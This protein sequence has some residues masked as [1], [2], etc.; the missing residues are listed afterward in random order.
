MSEDHRSRL[1]SDVYSG[2]KQ[3]SIKRYE[4]RGAGSGRSNRHV[5]Y[6]NITNYDHYNQGGWDQIGQHI[7]IKN[8]NSDDE[9]RRLYDFM[10][11]YKPAPKAAAPVKAAA[12][13]KAATP[14]FD[15]RIE[16]IN[17]SY[18]AETKRLTDLMSKQQKDYE[19]RSTNQLNAFNQRSAEQQAAFDKYSASQDK[20]ISNL[21]NSV[22]NAASQFDPTENM[23]SSNNINPALTIQEKGKTLSKGTSRYNRNSA[24]NIQNVNV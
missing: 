22:A 21:S 3:R 6:Q 14:A 4:S 1:M 24:L 2:Y 16:D 19:L 13:P 8:V 17:K 12:P 9:I 7:G 5:G 10:N 18:F 11:G 15:K 23:G 20:K